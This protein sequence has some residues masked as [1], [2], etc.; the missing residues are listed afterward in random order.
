[1]ASGQGYDPN[2]NIHYTGRP[3]GPPGEEEEDQNQVGQHAKGGE[4]Q[5]EAETPSPQGSLH[6]HPND[7]QEDEDISG[8]NH[9]DEGG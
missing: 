8:A 5:G 2:R 9:L 4:A 3:L 7:A 6:H 1:M